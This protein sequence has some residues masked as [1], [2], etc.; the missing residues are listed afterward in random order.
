MITNRIG[1]DEWLMSLAVATAKRGTCARRQ[2]GCVLVNRRYQ[3]IATGY[4]GNARGLEHCI[5]RPCPGVT[6][7]SGV[8]L[9]LCE[10][11]HAEQ[12]AIVNCFDASQ[13]YACYCTTEPCVPC[14]KLLINTPC[15]RVLF[16]EPYP[17]SAAA[18]LWTRAKGGRHTWLKFDP[19]V[20]ETSILA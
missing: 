10:A 3:V 1:R 19:G 17:A 20:L 5:D 11:V 13:I 4:N 6:L 14:A 7:G 8:G 15:E 2:V 16:L 18:V 9:D 12:N